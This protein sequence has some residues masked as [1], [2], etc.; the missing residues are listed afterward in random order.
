MVLGERG[1]KDEHCGFFL[2]FVGHL[3]FIVKSTDTIFLSMKENYR[4]VRS[5]VEEI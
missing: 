2:S 4:E 1:T 3:L 5:F